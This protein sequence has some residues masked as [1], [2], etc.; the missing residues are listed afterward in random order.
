MIGLFSR[1]S[2]RPRIARRNPA[3]SALRLESLET[4]ATPSASLAGVTATWSDPTHVVISGT[5][6]DDS[7]STVL[8]GGAAAATTVT[9]NANGDFTVALTLTQ[10]GT[11][12]LAPQQ[13]TVT[14]TDSKSPVTIV[15]KDQSI[16]SNVKITYEDGAW[17]I[18]GRV[19]NGDPIGTIISIISSDPS[20]NG[21]KTVVENPD[22]SFDIGI[23]MPQG[24]G[25]GSISII[26]TDP[27]GNV[28]GEWDGFIG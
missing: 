12:L 3:F 16:I 7:A 28:I 23:P 15:S 21:Q 11:V 25:G 5:V 22:G 10:P 9:A 19:D 26:A 13:G 20:I 27:N 4:R 1:P 6:T 17:H 2:R 8:V 24:N 18:R 14:A